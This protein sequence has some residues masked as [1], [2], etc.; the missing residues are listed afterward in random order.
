M[1][2]ACQVTMEDYHKLYCDHFKQCGGALVLPKFSGSLYQEGYGLGS[3]FGSIAR[4][5]AP[6]VK[7]LAPR[8]IDGIRD[9]ATT[10]VTT[11]SP[12]RRAALKKA[13][14]RIGL[15]LAQD[16]INKLRGNQTGGARR[17]AAKGPKK[18]KRKQTTRRKSV[19]RPTAVKKRRVSRRSSL[20]AQDIFG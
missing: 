19:S 1:R 16:T 8:A 13:A 12:K 3:V 2:A 15:D 20:R 17:R 7:L 6:L 5:I 9:L 14:K 4:W 11:P 18:Y 10:A